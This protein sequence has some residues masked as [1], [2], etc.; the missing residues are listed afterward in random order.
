[1]T[2]CLRNQ[3][4]DSKVKSYYVPS[5]VFVPEEFESMGIKNTLRS[6]LNLKMLTLSFVIK[7]WDAFSW[8]EKNICG[9]IQFPACLCKQQRSRKSYFS[10][11]LSFKLVD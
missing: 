6:S 7:C 4:A 3:T 1:M 2:K 8:E 11:R 10:D 5:F 9:R